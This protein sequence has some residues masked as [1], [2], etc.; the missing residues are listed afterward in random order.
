MKLN[1]CLK[2]V[3]LTE[4]TY[5]RPFMQ[6]VGWKIVY[7]DSPLVSYIYRIK[8]GVRNNFVEWS[9]MCRFPPGLFSIWILYIPGYRQ[10][11][12]LNFS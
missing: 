9:T 10:S 8:I 11:E 5:T 7:L 12:K 3:N 2:C 6:G 1:T 4:K